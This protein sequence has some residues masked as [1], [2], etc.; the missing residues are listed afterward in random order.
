[1]TRELMIYQSEN[2]DLRLQ[3]RIRFSLHIAAYVLF[4]VVQSVLLPYDLFAL[5]LRSL[6]FLTIIMHVSWLCSTSRPIMSNW[7]PQPQ[8]I[9]L[10]PEGKRRN[11]QENDFWY[12]W[13]DLT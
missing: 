7:T 2:N 4:C 11:L 3:R 13:H 12:R 9:P 6:L 1:M 10:L 5:S 8:P